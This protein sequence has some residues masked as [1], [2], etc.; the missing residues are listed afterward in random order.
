MAC[1]AIPNP[2]FP[3]G[4]AVGEADVVLAAIGALAP[5]VV[6]ELEAI[7]WWDWEHER[8]RECLDD[9]KDL[10]RFLARHGR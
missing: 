5:E 6:A 10:R 3:P 4:D 7:A 9:F 8:L 2:R 1:I